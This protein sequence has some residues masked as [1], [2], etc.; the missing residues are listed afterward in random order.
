MYSI[1]INGVV[2]TPSY[3]TREEAVI[4]I[5]QLISQGVT[6]VGLQI[7][8]L[9]TSTLLSQALID[10][11]KQALTKT[12]MVVIRCSIA[13]ISFPVEWKNYVLALRAIVNGTDTTSTE[14]PAQP[15][16]P[17]GT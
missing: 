2:K 15:S 3:P 7:N 14:L 12:D 16:Y 1:N 17:S 10:T 11:A 9:P 6:G 13:G 5:E 8:V 4:A